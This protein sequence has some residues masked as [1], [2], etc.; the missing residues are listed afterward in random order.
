MY[1]L[2]W[3]VGCFLF[4]GLFK[5]SAAEITYSPAVIEG[6]RYVPAAISIKGNIRPS[7][8]LKFGSIY[9]SSLSDKLPV[10]EVWLLGSGGGDLESALLIGN[11][12]DNL[13]LKVRVID[14]CYSAC[15]FIALAAK[16]RIFMGDLG[17]HRPYFDHAVNAQL[18][19]TEAE[20]KYSVLSRSVRNYLEQHGM[21]THAIDKTFLTSSSDVWIVNPVQANEVFGALKPSFHEWVKSKCLPRDQGYADSIDVDLRC[22]QKTLQEAQLEAI[23][24]VMKTG[25]IQK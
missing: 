1:R 24:S 4:F 22:L 5:A 7:D 6:D 16:Y 3:Q 20:T 12:I 18:T 19:A 14:D 25:G 13:Y 10:E 23:L 21:P 11:A 8:Y 2:T 15:A 9:R 17:L